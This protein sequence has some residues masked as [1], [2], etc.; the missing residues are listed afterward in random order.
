MSTNKVY[1]KLDDGLVLRTATPDDMEAIAQFNGK[2]HVDPGEDF[3]NHIADWTRDLGNG[4]HPTTRAGDFTLVEDT[5]TGAIV[6][7]MCLVGQ[8]WAYEGIEFPL[9]RPELV[10]TLEDYRRRGLIRRQFEIIH[11][12]SAERG[13]V[14]QFITGIPWYYRQFGYEMAVNLGGRRQ[15]YLANIPELKEDEKEA[16]RFRKAKQEDLGFITRVYNQSTRRSMLSCVRDEAI[17]D[18]ELNSRTKMASLGLDMRIIETPRGKSVGYLFTVPELYQGRVYVSA[19]EAA[20]GQS[21]SEIAHPTLRQIKKIGEEYAER[22]STEE[23]ALEMNGY[24]FSLGE[25]HPIYDV[26]PNRMPL[27]YDPYAFYIRIPHLVEFVQLVSPVLEKRLAQ[28]YM[29]G[30]S[31]ELKLNFYTHGINMEFK[32]GK[33]TSIEPWEQPERDDASAHFPDLTFYQLLLGY[34]DVQELEDAYAD[35][36][37]PKEEAKYLLKALFPK[38]PSHVLDFG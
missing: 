25:D 36:Y 8:T 18:Y 19:L 2:L 34:R 16:V 28:S 14:M 35:L 33:I 26:I 38:K 6:S 10:G 30:H 31:G 21:W 1:Q 29:V 5:N 4:K 9:G 23:K 11:Q 22:D 12:M 15:G 20:E 32:K 24:S 7:T 27:K 13:H 37:Y 17:W 3:V